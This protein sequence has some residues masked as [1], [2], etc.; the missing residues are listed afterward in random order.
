MYFFNILK[1]LQCNKVNIR[2]LE[3]IDITSCILEDEGWSGTACTSD[4][5]FFSFDDCFWTTAATTEFWIGESRKNINI[6]KILESN[7]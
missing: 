1:Q 6:I 7:L 3:P 5:P 4:T 2:Y